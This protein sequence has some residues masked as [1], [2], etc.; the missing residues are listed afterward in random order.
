AA[1][2]LTG[3]GFMSL[4]CCASNVQTAGATVRFGAGGRL[5]PSADRGAVLAAWWTTDLLR[6]AGLW[7]P[8]GP[9]PPLLAAAMAVFVAIGVLC[10]L[11]ARRRISLRP[12]DGVLMLL[13]LMP[14]LLV[15]SGFGGPALNPYGFD[16]TGRY[17]P[18]IWSALAVV[19]GAVLGVVWQVRR[20]L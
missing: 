10:A 19:L 20:Y 6:G 5:Y 16:A 15:F 17:T 3:L 4:T 14:T 11:L 12:L 13:V 9:S 1:S 18:P 8:W 2:S 7:H